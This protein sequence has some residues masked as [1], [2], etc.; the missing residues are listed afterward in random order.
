MNGII[1]LIKAVKIY[2]KKTVLDEVSLS[3][4]KR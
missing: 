1:K 2:G 4:K 3:I